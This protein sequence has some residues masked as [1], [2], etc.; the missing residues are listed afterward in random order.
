M[1]KLYYIYDNVADNYIYFCESASDA[2]AIRA[3]KNACEG[4]F[5]Q[6]ATDLSFYC[7]GE[8]KDGNIIP[9]RVLVYSN[10]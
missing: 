8:L 2:V 9:D 6:V 1:R 10:V 5:K 4:E 7:L 3:F